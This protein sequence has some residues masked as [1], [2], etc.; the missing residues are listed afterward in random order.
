[1]NEEGGHAK[2]CA[3]FGLQRF[4]LSTESPAAAPKETLAIGVISQAAHDLR[5]FR[6]ATNA[7]ERELYRDAYAWIS[8]NDFSWPYSFVSACKSLHVSPEMIRAELLADVSLGWFGRWT[9]LRERL[10]RLFRASFVR[11]FTRSRDRNKPESS[12]STH[13][14]QRT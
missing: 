3:A 8:A 7:V 13:A 10:S 14:F 6:S 11:V 4:A 2:D 9:R 12:R 5:K 1:V